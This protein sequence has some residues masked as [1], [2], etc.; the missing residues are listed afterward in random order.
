MFDMIEKLTNANGVSG[1][2][3]RVRD[4]IVENC[5]GAHVDRMGNVIVH[6]ERES[7]KKVM[8]CAH[9]DEVGF[10]V[11]NITDEGY[12]KFKAIGGVDSAI[13]PAK[14]VS[15]GENGVRGVIG[16]RPKH[17][18]KKEDKAT[19]KTEDLY[20][21]IGSDNKM[22]AMEHVQIGDYIAFVSE[23][24]EFGKE[25]IKAKALDDRVG[26]AIL[27]ELMKNEFPYDMHYVFTVQ[28]EIGCRGA[29]AL[30]N[31]IKP[32]LA[33]IVE[34]TMCA[35]LPKMPDE[36]AVT[37]MGDGPALSIM[38]S[39]CIYD[40]GT[41]NSLREYAD[42]KGIRVQ[43]KAAFIG[44]NDSGKIHVKEGGVPTVAVNVPCRYIHS[45]NSV[46]D[47]NDIVGTLGLLKGWLFDG[48]F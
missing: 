21:D 3:W 18:I 11:S 27:L 42:E 12:L 30:S 8:L 24:E 15:V 5:E 46:A 32:D 43:Y 45:P 25:K 2:E 40:K 16:V 41:T 47:K 23:Y 19:I 29:M 26:C 6:R 1:N 34:G 37:K 17:L 9:M 4:I 20:I 13:L 33:I 48:K 39:V 7:A 44:G 14:Q 28:E 10:I 22:N 38:D 35:D 36:K 31:E